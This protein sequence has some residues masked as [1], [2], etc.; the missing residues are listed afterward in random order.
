VGGEEDVVS[1]E[2]SS[3]ELLNRFIDVGTDKNR[4]GNVKEELRDSNPDLLASRG[5]S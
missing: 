3:L 2:S 1:G 4:F 5:A